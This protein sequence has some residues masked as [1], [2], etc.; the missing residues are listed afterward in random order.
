MSNSH[1]EM[2][3]DDWNGFIQRLTQLEHD[4]HRLGLIWTRGELVDAKITAINE[5]RELLSDEQ[6]VTGEQR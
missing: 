6:Q 4:A 3:L 2:S 1:T 5:A